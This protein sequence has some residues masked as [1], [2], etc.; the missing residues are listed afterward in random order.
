MKT[1]SRKNTRAKSTIVIRQESFNSSILSYEGLHDSDQDN[2]L[3]NTLLQKPS[4]LSVFSKNKK[5]LK[6]WPK[7]KNNLSMFNSY[8]YDRSQ[9]LAS[10][11]GF[12]VMKGVNKYNGLAK[13]IK[14]INCYDFGGV[15]KALTSIK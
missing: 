5:N 1:Y 13:I 15:S 6:K 2:I 9:I 8:Q 3:C 14:V 11:F 12:E 7:V 4:N 10:G